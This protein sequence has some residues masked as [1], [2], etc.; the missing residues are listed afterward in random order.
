MLTWSNFVKKQEN[1]FKLDNIREKNS[2]VDFGYCFGY[3]ITGLGNKQ[4]LGFKKIAAEYAQ[5]YD[6]RSMLGGF[7]GT[8]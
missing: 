8:M 5:K 7:F 3:F 2:K 4:K 6:I 1:G